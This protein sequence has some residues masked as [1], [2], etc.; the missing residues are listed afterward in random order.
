MVSSYNNTQTNPQATSKYHMH[1]MAARR[2]QPSV[3]DT[4]TIYHKLCRVIN[5]L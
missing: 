2:L 4:T 1:S 3:I 5:S